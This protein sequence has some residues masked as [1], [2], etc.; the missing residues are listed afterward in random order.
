MLIKDSAPGR[1]SHEHDL[2]EYS[3]LSTV[4]N[5]IWQACD[6]KN[7]LKIWPICIGREREE[8]RP[9]LI[10]A[11]PPPDDY[12]ESWNRKR[13]TSSKYKPCSMFAICRQFP[14]PPQPP[15]GPSQTM[16]RQPPPLNPTMVVKYTSTM[17]VCY[18][19]ALLVVCYK[20]NTSHRAGAY[21]GHVANS[22]PTTKSFVRGEFA[23]RI[24]ISFLWLFSQISRV[25]WISLN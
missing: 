7:L 11:I 22:C 17:A 1:H 10:F 15:G 23:I 9:S 12:S 16:G 2:D 18:K 25:A 3:N 24:R 21:L 8:Q 5:T 6:I 19:G 14:S 13:E 20:G 4:H